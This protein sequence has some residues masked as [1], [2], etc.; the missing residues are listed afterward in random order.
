MDLVIAAG[1]PQYTPFTLAT[2]DALRRALA[3]IRLTRV[4]T[5]LREF[6]AHSS[7]VAV[8]VFGAG[9]LEVSPRVGHI[10]VTVDDTAWHWAD[11]SGTPVVLQDLPS[12][13]H[14][15]LIELA[16]AN[17]RIVDKGTISFEVPRR[18]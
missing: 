6:D 17:H 15:V 1:L 9:A 11:A 4:A 12:G 18:P 14:R 5:S 10:H 8:P 7:A 3:V 13:P 16:D 2:A